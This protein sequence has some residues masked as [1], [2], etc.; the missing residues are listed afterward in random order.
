MGFPGQSAEQVEQFQEVGLAGAVLADEDVERSEVEV[1][2]GEAGEV[3]E[4]EAF[5]HG[6]EPR[7]AVAAGWDAPRNTLYFGAWSCSGIAAS[8]H[9]WPGTRALPQP[10]RGAGSVKFG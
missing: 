8:L 9:R 3:V 1:G 2:V 5:D 6:C 10:S 7:V 4:A